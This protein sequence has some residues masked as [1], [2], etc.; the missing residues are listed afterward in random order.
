MVEFLCQSFGNTPCNTRCVPPQDIFTTLVD[1]QWR[2][3]L[4]VFALS[5]F[6]SW[7]GFALVWWLIVVTHNDLELWSPTNITVDAAPHH[8]VT[9]VN[10]F[11]SAF[12]FSV[13]TQHTIGE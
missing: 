7:F 3:T 1:A 5:F 11:T 13:E 2:W 8:C 12:L 4:L 9:N 10:G 6:L